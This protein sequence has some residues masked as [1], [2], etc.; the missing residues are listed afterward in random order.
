LEILNP[1]GDE[2]KI[3]LV[4]LKGITVYSDIL[5]GSV[6]SKRIDVAALPAGVYLLKIVSGDIVRIKKIVVK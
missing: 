6:I 2:V 1:R 3:E 5:H 4:N